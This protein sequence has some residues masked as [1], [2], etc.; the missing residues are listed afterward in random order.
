MKY[1]T[2]MTLFFFL[3]AEFSFSQEREVISTSQT[4]R[5]RLEREYQNL[6]EAELPLNVRAQL[7]AF[8]DLD[9][10][11]TQPRTSRDQLISWRR[12][13]DEAQQLVRAEFGRM[14]VVASGNT[15]T[16]WHLVVGGRVV[17]RFV[18]RV[19]EGAHSVNY[20]T[21]QNTIV[22]VSIQANKSLL[23]AAWGE[24]LYA[25]H[26]IRTAPILSVGANGLYLEQEF[27]SGGNLEERYLAP[28]RRPTPELVADAFEQWQRAV[29]MHV[30]TGI[31]HDFKP[32]NFL[33]S[34]GRILNV[35]IAPLVNEDFIAR[36]FL[37]SGE[38][39]LMTPD[40]FVGRFFGP[41]V[42]LPAPVQPSF[43][44]ACAAFGNIF[45]GLS[46]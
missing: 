27:I 42:T 46:R 1:F 25:R 7:R 11:I 10:V 37:A 31:W 34:G 4:Y 29:R 30:A 38:S 2:F 26:G 18:K 28:R 19:G 13:A 40:E 3:A 39:R 23:L 6:P 36:A 45:R 33:E 41:G 35:D 20:L 9:Q 21:D 8:R 16:P 22:K 14:S 15:Q 43:G 17:H 5:A 12:Q 44:A 32:D 24:D